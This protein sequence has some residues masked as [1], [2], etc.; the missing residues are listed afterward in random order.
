MTPPP[1]PPAWHDLEVGLVLP[2]RAFG[3]AVDVEGLL[4]E[5]DVHYS[6]TLGSSRLLV[7]PRAGTFSRLSLEWQTLPEVGVF[8]A[9]SF[10]PEEYD[11]GELARLETWMRDVASTCQALRGRIRESAE[12]VVRDAAEGL[13]RSLP[14]EAPDWAHVVTTHLGSLVVGPPALPPQLDD[15]RTPVGVVDV[16]GPSDSTAGASRLEPAAVDEWVFRERA[17]GAV[18]GRRRVQ[19]LG[20]EAGVLSYE[21]LDAR[22]A[23]SDLER[24]FDQHIV[25]EVL[26]DDVWQVYVHLLA[27]LEAP[28]NVAY[29]G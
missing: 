17:G 23:S 13:E 20:G 18:L 9:H 24:W 12:R 6:A 2:D 3:A 11:P 5:P 22:V 10:P 29:F 26:F 19:R 21:V 25:R 1:A 4:D 28:L 27:G 16:D 7:M 15:E 14:D 8:A